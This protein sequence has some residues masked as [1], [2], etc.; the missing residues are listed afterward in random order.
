MQTIINWINSGGITSYL[1]ILLSVISVAIIINRLIFFHI[2]S[3]TSLE[4]FTAEIEK[5]YAVKDLDSIYGFCETSIAPFANITHTI[6]SNTNKSHHTLVKLADKELNKNI[7]ELEKYVMFLGTIANVSVYLG[8]LG[9]IFG[10]IQAFTNISTQ[11]MGGIEVVIGGVSKA[12]ITTAMGLI[13]AI[14]AVIF[15]NYFTDRVEGFITDM[16]LLID[17]ALV[18]IGKEN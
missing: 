16:E 5:F 3:R 11:G 15:F 13:V 10:I 6:F 17:E 7:K 8:L 14:P 9:T 2:K 18:L 1:L 12:L 4:N